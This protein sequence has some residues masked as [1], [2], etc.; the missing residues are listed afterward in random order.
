M[1]WWTINCNYIWL[2]LSNFSLSS[3]L[4]ISC[5]RAW[6]QVIFS[7]SILWQTPLTPDK[8]FKIY[9]IELHLRTYDQY[10][11]NSCFTLFS[12]VN[13][14]LI[15]FHKQRIWNYLWAEERRGSSILDRVEIIF[16]VSHSSFS[17]LFCGKI[18]NAW[19]FF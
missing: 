11:K 18:L 2:V 14:T 7:L 9:I 4:I 8:R 6:S 3:I 1:Y 19:S 13:W 5:I 17:T 10:I 16:L 12:R 15:P